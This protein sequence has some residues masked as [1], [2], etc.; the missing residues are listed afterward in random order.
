MVR[1]SRTSNPALTF[2][3]RQHHGARGARTGRAGHESAVPSSSPGDQGLCSKVAAK[4]RSQHSF[5]CR[6]A[7]SPDATSMVASPAPDGSHWLFT[8]TTSAAGPA[9]RLPVRVKDISPDWSLRISY[10]MFS[11]V[12]EPLV[13]GRL[14][15]DIVTWTGEPARSKFW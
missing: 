3:V 2:A 13:S 6:P 12:T 8:R 1:Q 4:V 15:I 7:P 9:T 10:K 5:C 11:D 14:S